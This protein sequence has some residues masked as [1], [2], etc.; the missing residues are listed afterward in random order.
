MKRIM[1]LEV[2]KTVNYAGGIE[3]VLCNFSNE[4]VKRGYEVTYVCLDREKGMP[5]YPLDKRV[6]FV[7]LCYEYPHYFGVEYYV[8]RA[9]KELKKVYLGKKKHLL[10]N[11]ISDPKKNYFEKQFI[12]RLRQYLHNNEPDI[13]IGADSQAV[14]IAQEA[15]HDTIPT[16]AMCHTDPLTLDNIPQHEIAAWR[17]TAAVQV[18]LDEYRQQFVAWGIKNI[19]T[20]A[21]VVVQRQVVFPRSVNQRIICAARLEKI[22]KRPHLL[23]ES[24]GMVATKYPAW[25][26]CFCG[27]ISSAGYKK[28][29]DALV[30]KY[31]INKQVVFAGQVKNIQEYLMQA[32]IFAM[33]SNYEGFP[34][35]LTEAMSMGLAVV[36]YR[37]CRAAE[38]LIVNGVTGIL[39]ES[40]VEPLAEALA[41]LIQ[42]KEKR[43]AL[44]AKAQQAMVEFAPQKIWNKWEGLINTYAR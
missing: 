31:K 18:L 19:V 13:M 37:S 36:A 1:L 4:F 8:T 16:V 35:A 42:N 21:N 24:F 39:S 10:G 44:G 25:Q 22:Q 33:P 9:A 12:F 34:L 2:Y 40:G 43:E 38:S 26:L 27:E 17:K 20:I 15:C 3:R 7:N 6:K 28:Q 41:A 11:T 23:L 14:Y 5:F 29:L 30:N 32:D